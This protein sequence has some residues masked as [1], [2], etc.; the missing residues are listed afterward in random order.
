MRCTFARISLLARDLCEFGHYWPRSVV[1]RAGLVHFF[2]LGRCIGV[3]ERCR[4]TLGTCR[5]TPRWLQ[6]ITGGRNTMTRGVRIHAD[7]IVGCTIGTYCLVGEWSWY[8]RH[9]KLFSILSQAMFQPAERSVSLQVATTGFSEQ[10]FHP[11]S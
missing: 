4:R 11:R 5:E 6:T 3:L 8:C 1:I 2:V 9:L 7:G 10:S